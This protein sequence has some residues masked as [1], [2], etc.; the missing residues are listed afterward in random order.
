MRMSKKAKRENLYLLRC[1]HKLTQAEFAAKIGVS[2]RGY[3]NVEWGERQGTADFWAAIQR[4]FNV[5]DEDMYAL[6]KLEKQVEEC[7]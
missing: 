3:Q 7:E 4:V 1:K 5:K 6:M 2:C